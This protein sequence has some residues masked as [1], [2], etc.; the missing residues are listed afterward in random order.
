MLIGNIYVL[1]F[2]AHPEDRNQAWFP[3]IVVLLGL[4]LAF[5]S[6]LMLPLD[7]ANRN[8]CDQSKIVSACTFTLPMTQLWCVCGSAAMTWCIATCVALFTLCSQDVHLY[9]H[10]HLHL[11][12]HPLHTFLL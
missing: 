2:Y 12:R 1:A 3:K 6:V 11:F 8:A 4:T 9:D 5:L 7:R 10:D